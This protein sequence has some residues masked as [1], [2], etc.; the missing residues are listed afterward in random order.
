VAHGLSRAESCG[1]LLR[2]AESCRFKPIF[3]IIL[4]YSGCYGF[5]A[6]PHG[7]PEQT[8]QIDIKL[9]KI[10]PPVSSTDYTMTR[11]GVAVPTALMDE[12][13]AQVNDYG[14]DVLIVDNMAQVF[15]ANPTS[16]T[17]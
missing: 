13:E 9:E 5:H 7:F 3:F 6:T 8:G 2:K 16:S 11:G 15:G 4:P 10:L 1:A 14:A 17:T 12:L